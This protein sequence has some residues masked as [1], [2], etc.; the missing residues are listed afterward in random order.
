MKARSI[1]LFLSLAAGCRSAPPELE[2]SSGNWFNAS[3][4]PLLSDLRGR[5]V[6]LEF[7]FST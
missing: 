1:F 2:V 5:V 7:G 4:A 6:W 3:K